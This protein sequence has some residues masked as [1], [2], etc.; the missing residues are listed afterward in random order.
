MTEDY[1]SPSH[2]FRALMYQAPVNLQRLSKL[3]DKF[4]VRF[5]RIRPANSMVDRGEYQVHVKLPDGCYGFFEPGGGPAKGLRSYS[6]VSSVEANYT[7][8]ELYERRHRE[9]REFIERLDKF[10]KDSEE[11][12]KKDK[13]KIK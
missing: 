10:E 5:V 6:W 11:K 9:I 8:D 7:K 2:K 12:F 4:G 1:N 13:R 3:A